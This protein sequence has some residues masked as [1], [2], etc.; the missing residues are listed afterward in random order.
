MYVDI[1]FE[2]Y[3]IVYHA[4]ILAQSYCIPTRACPACSTCIS[5]HSH[6]HLRYTQHIITFP[7]RSVQNSVLYKCNVSIMRNILKSVAVLYVTISESLGHAVF[8][9]SNH[10]QM[11]L[12][13][14]D[15]CTCLYVCP[16]RLETRTK[17]FNMCA[18]HWV[19]ETQRRSESKV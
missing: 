17:E 11:S 16:T 5:Q 10:K 13:T 18:S 6:M 7:T 3:E 19:F 12:R 9:Y 8:T 15:I 1:R 4:G 14:C 2:C